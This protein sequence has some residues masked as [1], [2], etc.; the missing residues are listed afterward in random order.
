MFV[1][2][3]FGTE[4]KQCK[5][6][7]RGGWSEFGDFKARKKAGQAMREKGNQSSQVILKKMKKRKS[8]NYINRIA[9]QRF[10]RA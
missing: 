10:A 4:I 2:F 5:K 3:P 8:K 7:M 9:K 6:I 1:K